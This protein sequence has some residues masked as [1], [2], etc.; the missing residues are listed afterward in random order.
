MRKLIIFFL[1]TILVS[2]SAIGQIVIPIPIPTKLMTEHGF[3]PGKKFKF[4]PTIG[5]YNFNGL[6]IRMELFDARDFSANMRL[7]CSDLELTNTSEFANPACIYKFGEYFDKL[8]QQTGALIDSSSSD[9]LQVWL[10]GVDARLIGFGYIRAHGL[11]QMRIKYHNLNKTYCTDI[12]DADPCSPINPN[13]MVTRLTATRIMGS[14][15]MREVIENFFVDLRD[16]ER[17]EKK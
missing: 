17:Q 2:T 13:A 5:N 3:L 7:K 4:L 14:A 9:T 15:S 1:L 10:E 6:K 11:C 16:I 12:T 8:L